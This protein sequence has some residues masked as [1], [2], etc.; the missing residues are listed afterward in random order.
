MR[1]SAALGWVGWALALALAGVLLTELA[2]HQLIDHFDR[3]A[4]AQLAQAARGDTPYVWHFRT[5]DELVRGR[6]FGG[7]GFHFDAQGLHLLP[8]A[9]GATEVGLVLAVPLDLQRYPRLSW[10]ARGA[11]E[12]VHLVVRE[13]L[14]APQ[15][16]LTLPAADGTVVDLTAAAWRDETGAAVAPP[17]RAAML[18]LHWPAAVGGE[19]TLTELRLEAAAAMR[20]PE[21]D[22]PLRRWPATGPGPDGNCVLVLSAAPTPAALPTTP[23]SDTL[24]PLFAL[25]RPASA[26]QTLALR[27]RLRAR[28][29][30]AILLA[31]GEDIDRVRRLARS[32]RGNVAVSPSAPWDESRMAAVLATALGLVLLRW[33]PPRAP[34]SRA[35]AEVIAVFAVPC[36]LIVAGQFGDNPPI[37]VWTLLALPLLFAAS[38]PR[39]GH[40]ATTAHGG[41]ATRWQA[42]LGGGAVLLLAVLAGL[43]LGDGRLRAPEVAHALRYLVWAGLQQWL[44]CVVLA[45]RLRLLVGSARWAAL[46]AAVVFALMHTPNQALMQFTLLGALLWVPLW[47]RSRRLLPLVLSHAAS[48]LVLGTLLP[49]EILR[50][51][52]VSARFFLP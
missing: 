35:A 13:T 11:I 17:T 30:T 2:R 33:R 46:L 15:R 4:A 43:L 49:P 1:L 50:S 48:G 32:A 25:Q 23:W 51:A 28:F 7:A 3:S 19:A 31:G 5:R 52:E 14:D 18:R 40:T 36:G 26:E 20:R 41:H 47:L 37:W 8:D 9:A 42:W 39:Y 44:L 16:L 27:D 24:L 45:D 6:P 29:P 12:P 38:L 34:R 21:L 22:R 10:H